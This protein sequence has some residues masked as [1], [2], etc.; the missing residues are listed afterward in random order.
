MKYIPGKSTPPSGKKV[1]K[2]LKD[3]HNFC[4]I[5]RKYG[6]SDNAVRKWMRRDDM[7]PPTKNK[8]SRIISCDYCGKN[9]MKQHNR[10]EAVNKSFC[11]R[12]CFHEYQRKTSKIADLGVGKFKDLRNKGMSYRDIGKMYDI[13]HMCVLRKFKNIVKKE[14]S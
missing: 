1:L 14:T 9:S 7:K 5:G 2:M 8:P 10:L 4:S 12:Q 6:V 13:D 3:G 11:N